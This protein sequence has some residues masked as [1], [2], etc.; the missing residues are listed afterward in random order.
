MAHTSR[1][2]RRNSV[3]GRTTRKVACSLRVAVSRPMADVVAWRAE[4]WHTPTRSSEIG[5]LSCRWGKS[6]TRRSPDGLPLSSA[7][8]TS[9]HEASSRGSSPGRC[10]RQTRRVSPSGLMRSRSTSELRK[11]TIPD[12][13]KIGGWPSVSL[14]SPDST[15]CSRIHT[16]RVPS[17]TPAASRATRSSYEERQSASTSSDRISERARS[18][19]AAMRAAASA[20]AA[21]AAVASSDSVC[22]RTSSVSYQSAGMAAGTWATR[23]ASCG[24]WNRTPSR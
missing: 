5:S 24:C 2:V 9:S 17:T 15:I 8:G 10:M 20:A 22:T 4:M 11:W 18:S 14:E 3:L 23:A 12:G 7:F 1:R 19:L 6:T 13:S 21:P 16:L